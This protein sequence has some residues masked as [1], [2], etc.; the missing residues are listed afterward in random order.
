MHKYKII[1]TLMKRCTIF[2]ISNCLAKQF[3]CIYFR[4]TNK[5]LNFFM[6]IIMGLG[7]YSGG[8]NLAQGRQGR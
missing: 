4:Y 5:I 3:K 8:K 6:K 2:I 1:L 7:N